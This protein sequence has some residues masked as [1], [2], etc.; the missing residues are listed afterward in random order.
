MRLHKLSQAFSA[1]APLSYESVILKLLD[2]MREVLRL[3]HYSIRTERSYT[4]WVRRFIRFHKMTSREQMLPA[5]PKMEA[6]LSDLAVNGNLAVSTQNQAFNEKAN[7]PPPGRK[8]L[9]TPRWNDGAPGAIAAGVT[10]GS[11][12][13]KG[14]RLQFS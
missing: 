6:F 14:R 5:E 11:S 2:Q 8:H 7:P 3:K 13:S 10:E 4:D 9:P 12:S 1:N